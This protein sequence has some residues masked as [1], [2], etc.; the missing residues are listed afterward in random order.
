MKTPIRQRMKKITLLT[1][2]CFAILTVANSQ[3]LLTLRTENKVSADS[4]TPPKKTAVFEFKAQTLEYELNGIHDELPGNHP[5]G[6]QIA[7]KRYLLEEK[8]TSQVTIAPG[9]PA[10]K[11]VIRK[12]VIYE[13]VIRIE[14]DL[15]RMVKKNE[16][17][18]Q[19]A[20][21]KMNSVLDVA[22]NIVSI[23]TDDFEK[24]LANCENSK[25]SIELFTEKVILKY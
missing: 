9:N 22:L 2:V 18:L 4:G 24:Q 3:T 20:T 12:P 21:D 19:I 1:I 14:K 7:R 10:T 13:A 11:T 15:R 5:F 17:T 25:S 16:I 6:K 23:N 8:Y